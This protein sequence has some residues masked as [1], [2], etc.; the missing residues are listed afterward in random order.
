MNEPLIREGA[1]HIPPREPLQLNDKMRIVHSYRV[2]YETT[3]E[4]ILQQP[5]EV[6]GVVYRQ[7]WFDG[8]ALISRL[9]CPRQKL[10]AACVQQLGWLRDAS[11]NWKFDSTSSFSFP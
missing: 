5:I 10:A 11:F 2:A 9:C 7:S 6:R 4:R 8:F 3:Y 1:L